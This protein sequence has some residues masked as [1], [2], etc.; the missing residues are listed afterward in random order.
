MRPWQFSKPKN[1]GFGISRS[2]YLSVLLAKANLPSIFEIVNPKS[3]FGAVEGF[4][5]PMATDEKEA[6]RRPPRARQVRD[7][8]ERPEDGHGDADPEQGGGGVR[9]RG[10]RALAAGLQRGPRAGGAG[11]GDVDAGTTDLQVARPDGLSGAGHSSV[12]RS[13]IGRAGGRSGGRP[14]RPTLSA[15]RAGFPSPTGSIRK[16]MHGTT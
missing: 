14:D 7:R 11:A 10:L 3:E 16:W 15:A 12:D 9:S 8:L 13:T 6:L 5:V 2:Y 1:P 4:G